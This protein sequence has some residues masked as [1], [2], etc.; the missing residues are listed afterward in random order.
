M[1]LPLWPG[2]TKASTFTHDMLAQYP[3]LELDTL[4]LTEA[5]RLRVATAAGAGDWVGM[6]WFNKLMVRY[7][8]QHPYTP[9]IFDWDQ[10]LPP[11]LVVAAAAVH[12]NRTKAARLLATHANPLFSVVRALQCDPRNSTADLV[13]QACLLAADES[14]TALCAEACLV[15]TEL[16][17]VEV[18]IRNAAL[19]RACRLHCC[20]TLQCDTQGRAQFEVGRRL[21]CWVPEATKELRAALKADD[22]FYDWNEEAFLLRAGFQHYHTGALALLSDFYRQFKKVL[23]EERCLQKRVELGDPIALRDLGNFY[24]RNNNVPEAY[25]NFA[26]IDPLFRFGLLHPV[27]QLWQNLDGTMIDPSERLR[28]ENTAYTQSH[29]QALL[30]LAGGV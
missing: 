28:A 20:D 5:G 15:V 30:Q 16:R 3:T 26:K 7:F 24:L 19:I 25:T 27:E 29:L 23:L 17:Q 11:A 4:L 18:S 2:Q 13:H 14:N 9:Y 8:A 6:V 1:A 10:A 21:F 12:P 22:T